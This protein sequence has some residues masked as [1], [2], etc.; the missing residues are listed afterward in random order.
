MSDLSY[1]RATIADIA[2]VTEAIA[3][4]ERSGA[5]ASVYERVF[6]LDRAGLAALLEAMLREE[7]AGSELCCDSFLLALDD[8]L[9]VGCIA[10]WIEAAEGMSSNLMRAHL[11]V[12]ALGAER[13]AAARPR[14]ASLAA[15][16]IPREPGALQIE[17]VYTAPAHRGRRVTPSLI[18]RALAEPGGASKAQILSVLG[19]ESSARAFTHAGF[20][21]A[22]Q[23]RS[24]DPA[25]RE[26]FP[27]TGRI[28][29]E[30]PLP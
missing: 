30:R 14:L 21:I 15:I 12:H 13:W 5:P 9:P 29:W 23:T 24:E 6:G 26:I 1:R 20:S 28:L 16:D 8:G 10:T 17:A 22:R 11:L 2:F 4:A 27:G 19:N 3:E 18:A 25:L 7:I